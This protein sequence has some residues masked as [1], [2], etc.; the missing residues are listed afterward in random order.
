MNPTPVSL[1]E[2]LRRPNEQAAW[3]EFVRLYGPLLFYWARKAGLQ[4][5]D[6]ADLTQEVF[7]IL[8]RKLP[9]F[10][11]DEHKSFRAWLR[12]I[13]LNK[14]RDAHRRRA[15]QP[16]T[17]D[18]SGFDD[19][20][21]PEESFTEQEYRRQLMAQALEILRPEFRALTWRAFEEHGVAGRRAEDVARALGMTVRAVYAAKFRVLAR[22]RSYLQ[23]LLE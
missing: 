6:A 15:R 22:L 7:A 1:L 14:W 18:G 21:G 10:R 20:P 3:V 2:Q 23:G 13:A 8:V 5:S 9:E 12:T 19:V 4:E 16:A 17:L 11:Y